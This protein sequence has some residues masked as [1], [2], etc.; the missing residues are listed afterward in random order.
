[1][2]VSSLGERLRSLR[3]RLGMTQAQLAGEDFTDSCVSLIE[4][5]KRVPSR[6]TLETFAQKLGCSVGY[7]E[8]GVSD[9]ALA[10]VEVWV[11]SAQAALD[12][13]EASEAAAC[14]ASI[15]GGHIFS[16]ASDDLQV[17]AWRGLAE[18]LEACGQVD[19]A[20]SAWQSAAAASRG[21]SWEAWSSIQVGLL[22]CI[23]RRGDLDEAV[24][25]GQQAL[26][27]LHSEGEDATDAWS[28][29]T[30]ALLEAY[31]WRGDQSVRRR[32]ANK[33]LEV[34]DAG[35]S[36]QMRLAVYA[37]VAAL[38]EADG[39]Q[40]VA[41]DLAERAL[42]SFPEGI[43]VQRSEPAAVLDYAR[44]LILADGHSYA[45]RARALLQKLDCRLSRSGANDRQRADCLIELAR[46]ELALNQPQQAAACARQAID[47]LGEVRANSLAEALAVQGQ[48]YVHLGEPAEAIKALTRCATCLEQ[49]GSS[50]RAARAWCAVVEV[51]DQ[52]GVG[53]RPQSVAYQRALVL[54]GL[55]PAPAMP[56]DHGPSPLRPTDGGRGSLIEERRG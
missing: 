42:A 12:R 20:I 54:A 24:D 2:S 27:R 14:F 19:D 55:M 1:M 26:A 45:E 6:Q 39:A 38:A 30:L 25:L 15:T 29:V 44:L 40:S 18:S 10:A 34:V 11:R 8:H 13:G 22:G 17:Q 35:G 5:G 49:W 41:V 36:V 7:L 53:R 51:L 9:E 23:C 47:V 21:M 37:R 56:S 52:M 31:E 48:A 33:L 28:R 3:T 43:A 50:R 16:R 32:L 4:T 46:A